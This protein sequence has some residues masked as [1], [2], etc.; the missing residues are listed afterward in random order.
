MCGNE[1]RAADERDIGTIRMRYA[2]TRFCR[3]RRDCIHRARVRPFRVVARNRAGLTEL[4]V[5][6]PSH[7]ISNNAETRLRTSP[8]GNADAAET[9]PTDR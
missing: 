7:L 4:A 2:P 8:P 6:S 3:A 5:G 9:M 1:T